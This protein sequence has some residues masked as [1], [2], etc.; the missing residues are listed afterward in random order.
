M[1]TTTTNG[2]TESTRQSITS[3]RRTPEAYF[4]EGLVPLIVRMIRVF[5]VNAQQNRIPPLQPCGPPALGLAP[6][7][8]SPSLSRISR[9]PLTTP[10]HVMP[11]APSR[12]K[13]LPALTARALVLVNSRKL[14]IVTIISSMFYSY[15]DP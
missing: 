2:N 15:G 11:L 14:V 9:P 7:K 5:R 3:A 6:A 10:V 4:P 12:V 13:L 1:V 8:P